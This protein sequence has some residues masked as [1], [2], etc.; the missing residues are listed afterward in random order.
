LVFGT[1]L[2][3][4]AD[5]AGW[6]LGLGISA[7]DA[8]FDDVDDLSFSDSDT[9]IQVKGGYMFN[10][11]F[12]LEGGYVDL[13]DYDGDGGIRIDADGFW[14]AGIG[15]WSVAENWDIY[16]KLGAFAVDAASDQVIPGIGMVKENDTETSF[17]GGVGVEYDFGEWNLFG[18]YAVVDT[19]ISNLN[20]TMITAGLKF[21]F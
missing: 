6:Y 5:D 12:G 15:N 9:A 16:G 20:V 18:E 17:F 1:P 21:E 7:L 8:D 3:Q 4:G 10:D 2:A 11:M 13:G 19:D 14:L